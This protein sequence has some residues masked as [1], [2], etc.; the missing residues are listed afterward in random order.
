MGLNGDTQEMKFKKLFSITL[1]LIFGLY[2]FSQEKPAFKPSGSPTFKIFSNYHSTFSDGE[3]FNA[4]EITR[5]YLGYKHNFSE[6]WSGSVIF[7]VGDPEDG[8]K[9]EMS[10]YVKIASLSYEK[11]ALTVDFGLISTTAFKTQEKFW[12]YRYLLKSFQDEYKSGSSADLGLSATYEFNKMFSADVIVVNGEGYKKIERDNIFSVGVGVTLKP[13]SGL[14]LRGYFETST[15]EE[16]IFKRQ[17]TLSVFA[18]FDHEA[19]SVGAEFNKQTNHK[20]M[21][22]RDWEGYSVFGTYIIK[23]TKLLARFDKLTSDG[24][25]N[26]S[27]DGNI[28]VVGAEFNPVKGVKITPN[29]RHYS[30]EASNGANMD[31]AYVNCEIKF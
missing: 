29:Y 30:P 2:A 27:E 6:N 19:F 4:F 15:K 31:F 24:G 26:A 16:G 11:E 7:D 13:V 9:H 14:I 28:F 20:M 23:S 25:F 8:G 22:G 18:G 21:E 3:V 17:N 5:A 1:L 12:G 10:A